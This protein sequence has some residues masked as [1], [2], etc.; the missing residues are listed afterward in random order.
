MDQSLKELY[1]SRIVNGV[2]RCKINDHFYIIKQPDRRIRHIAQ[3]IYFDA[4]KEAELDGLYNEDELNQ[5]LIDNQLWS[6]QKEKD[7]K[8]I[9]SDIDE[10]KVKL[11]QSIYKSEERKMLR[12]MLS[13]A[14]ENLVSLYQQ[15]N[16]YNHLSCDGFASTLKMRYLVGKSLKYEDDTNVWSN[17]DFWKNT[18]PILEEATSIYI[19]NKISEKHFRE[20][21]R[22]DP[23]RS[24]WSCRKVENALFGVPSVDL[25]DE[26]KNIVIWSN[27]YDNIYEHPNCPSE[28]VIHDDDMIDGWLILQRRERNKKQ[29][30]V[31]VEDFISNDKIK[32]SGEVFIIAQSKEDINRVDSLNDDQ[33]K[34]IKKQ[35]FKYINEKG[36]VDESQMPD[37]KFELQMQANRGGKK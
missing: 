7:L 13:I 25:T 8:Q 23:W 3:Q 36:H 4:I 32:N 24:I 27:L 26:Q 14:K 10:L 28:E 34:N 15:K 29:A 12:K 22:T 6:D 21:A 11:F 20:I 31:E 35:R 18:D 17:D 5:F 37:T 9:H 33:A 2:F 19:D 16:A 30:K 1:V